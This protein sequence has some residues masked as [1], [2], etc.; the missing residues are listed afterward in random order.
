MFINRE[1]LFLRDSPILWNTL[2]DQKKNIYLCILAWKY[3]QDLLLYEKHVAE[4]GL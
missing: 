3:I 1:Q 2:T 4:Q